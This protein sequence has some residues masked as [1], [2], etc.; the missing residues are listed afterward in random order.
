[1]NY[2]LLNNNKVIIAGEIYSELKFSH[3]V[4]GEV[5][6]ELMLGVKRK[7]NYLDIIPITISERLMLNEKFELGQKICIKGQF[8]SK[9]NEVKD[10]KS[11][12]ILTVFAREIENYI[13]DINQIEVN[14]IICK[15]PIYRITPLE[16][17][18]ADTIVAV[19]RAY[20]KSDYL[21]CI[22]WGRNAKYINSLKVGD[23]ICFDGRIQSREYEKKLE[24]KIETRIAYEISIFNIYKDCDNNNEI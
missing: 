18:I 21:P 14:G 7:S 4:K 6:Y 11:K 13:E 16:R 24:D 23:T 8:R 19:N 1:M 22:A 15:T 10:G 9:N 2:E 5:F 3:E 17:E 20:N 12:L